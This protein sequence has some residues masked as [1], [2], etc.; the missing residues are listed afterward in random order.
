M[1]LSLPATRP[2]PRSFA[3]L[4]ALASLWLGAQGAFCLDSL[5]Q[6]VL[7]VFAAQG[8]AS[9][10]TAQG[11]SAL[12]SNP[13]GFRSEPGEVTLLSLSP[14]IEGGLWEGDGLE[15]TLLDRAAA[16][17]ARFGGSAAIGYAGRGL[18]LGMFLAGGAHI[19]GAT[20]LAGEADFELG[21]IGGYSYA[22][23]L[24][25]L[26]LSLGASVR[27][28]LRADVPL[29]DVAA[30]DVIRAAGH[31]GV[32]LLDA[33]WSEDAL[34]GV[35]FAVDMGALVD[36]GPVRLGLL[37]RDVGNTTFT[38]S[39]ARFGD[40]VTALASLSNLPD[41]HATDEGVTVP[42][43][44]RFGAAYSLTPALLLQ[45]EISDP[46]P[47]LQGDTDLLD[48][49]HAGLR[50]AA[51]KRGRVWLGWEGTGFGAG[52]SLRLGPVQ[53]SLAL[54]GLDPRCAGLTDAGIAA[55][56]AIRF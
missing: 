17:G 55:E 20:V 53:T 44:V 37:F 48:S 2:G 52:A 45:A 19:Q 8:G 36:V 32:G 34:Y 26:D 21:L 50:L 5:V 13:A 39:R 10:A 18:G 22:L 47:A 25:G 33:L 1:S 3:L 24:L 41:G 15:A 42:M 46:L 27:P 14:W 16:G 7:P 6:P 35:A 23:H 49:L 54:Y 51:G 9:V 30:R 11:F 12:F 38:Y 29:D 28:L 56:T 4:A 40:V 31:G 43:Q